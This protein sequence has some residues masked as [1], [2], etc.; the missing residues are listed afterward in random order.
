MIGG[1]SCFPL[2][3]RL[4]NVLLKLHLALSGPLEVSAQHSPTTTQFR[5]LETKLVSN[6]YVSC[7]DFH[8]IGMGIIFTARKG[9]REGD[10]EGEKGTA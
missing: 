6:S 9:E 2:S 10:R 5:A 4:T 7:Y 1:Y 8:M 3:F